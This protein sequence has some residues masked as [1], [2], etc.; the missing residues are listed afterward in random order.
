MIIQT[1]QAAYEKALDL[2]EE[3]KDLGH[4][5]KMAICELEDTL[6]E[7]FESSKSEE[8]EYESSEDYDYPSDGDVYDYDSDINF[9]GR[10][11]YR[12]N[13]RSQM[14]DNDRYWDDEDTKHG[15]RSYRRGMRRNRM[16]RYV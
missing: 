11:S 10:R 16:G 9:K 1:R 13:R 5:K 2:I 15:M 12:M 4:K 7:C 3:M 14:R 8:D 6:Y